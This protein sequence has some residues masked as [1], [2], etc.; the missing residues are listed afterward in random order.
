MSLYKE[1]IQELERL[2]VINLMMDGFQA[3]IQ[4]MNDPKNDQQ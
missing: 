4:K 3:A 2:E 1:Y